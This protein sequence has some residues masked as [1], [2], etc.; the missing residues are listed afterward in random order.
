MS[1]VSTKQLNWITREA[2][3]LVQEHLRGRTVP[4]ALRGSILLATE[5]R[6]RR[7]PEPALRTEYGELLDSWAK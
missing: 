5:D 7:G 6:L 1:R 2:E 4:S 3:R